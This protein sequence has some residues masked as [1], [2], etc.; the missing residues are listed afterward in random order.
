MVLQEDIYSLTFVAL[1]KVNNPIL[2]KELEFKCMLTFLIQMSL[3]I[4]IS[5]ETNGLEDIYT[6]DLKLNS[7]RYMCCILLHLQVMPEFKS[8]FDMIRY[9][10]NNQDKFQE[11]KFF[12]FLVSVMKIF[13]SLFCEFM[14]IY[15][16]GTFRDS[17]TVIFG[18]ITFGIIINIDNLIC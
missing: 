18:Y 11:Q 10:A 6:G 7:T 9:A 14:N 2:C 13:S 16:M 3:C 1:I 4:V 17:A 15:I 8:A 12:P 5:L